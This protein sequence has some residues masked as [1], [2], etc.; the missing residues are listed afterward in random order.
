VGQGADF[1][2]DPSATPVRQVRHIKFGQWK[3]YDW[4]VFLLDRPLACAALGYSDNFVITDIICFQN[5]T[6]VVQ[7]SEDGD[8]Q[9]YLRT[10]Y[11]FPSQKFD[12]HLDMY[13]SNEI[14]KSCSKTIQRWT[15]GHS[16]AQ[17][18]VDDEMNCP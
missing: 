4:T 15:A 12:W 13:R 1:F 16:S 17:W 8:Q 18:S 2:K 5:G 3:H 9:F 14:R 11:W 6:I 7:Y 10:C